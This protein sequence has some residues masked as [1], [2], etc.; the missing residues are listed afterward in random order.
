MS[1]IK[2]GSITFKTAPGDHAAGVV[3]P[4]VAPKRVPGIVTPPKKK[5]VVRRIVPRSIPR[6]NPAK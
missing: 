2:V 4:P 3:A 5:M 6:R 1:T